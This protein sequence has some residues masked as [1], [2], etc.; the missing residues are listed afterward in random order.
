MWTV[1]IQC[2]LTIIWVNVVIV[3]NVNSVNI[4]TVIDSKIMNNTE[5]FYTAANHFAAFP[6]WGSAIPQF[7]M[8][9]CC[10]WHIIAPA[11]L[12]SLSTLAAVAGMLRYFSASAFRTVSHSSVVFCQKF[13]GSTGTT[14]CC[15]YLTSSMSDILV[16]MGAG[17]AWY[18]ASRRK[19]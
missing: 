17:S 5:K 13:C 4:N 14:G 1:L 2:R 3:M 12:K 18:V 7:Q 8:Q 6:F 11:T 19:W 10:E 16:Y 9:G 15:T